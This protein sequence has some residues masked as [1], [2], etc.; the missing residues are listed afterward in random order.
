MIAARFLDRKRREVC[1]CL[2][3]A[4]VN[5]HKSPGERIFQGL[6]HKPHHHFRQ[7]TA[8]S[9][10]Q[11]YCSGGP[12]GNNPSGTTWLGRIFSGARLGASSAR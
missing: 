3:E 2:G 1:G 7:T 9:A 4:L 8:N 6:H 10:P 11:R 5:S 12:I